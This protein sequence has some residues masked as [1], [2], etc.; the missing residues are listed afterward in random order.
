MVS[1]SAAVTGTSVYG[2]ILYDECR[3]CREEIQPRF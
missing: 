3:E 2:G 1:R